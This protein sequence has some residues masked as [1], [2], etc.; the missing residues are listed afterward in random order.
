MKITPKTT[1]RT[2]IK[3]AGA[4][5]TVLGITPSFLRAMGARPVRKGRL[6]DSSQKLNIACVGCGGKGISDVNDVGSENIV[7]LC[8]VD[9]VQAAKVYAKYP[10]VPK[11]KDFREML[12][13]MD[14]EIDAVT[15]STPD[16]VHYEVGMLAISMGKHVF[17]QKPLTHSIWEA[18]E[19]LNAA[20][21]HGVIT[22]MGNQGHAGEGVRLAREW[23]QAD[24][25]GPVREVHI[26]TSK[27]EMGAY[28][29]SQKT[30]PQPGEQVPASLDW[31]LWV[32]PVA[33]RP[34]S[35][36]YHPRKWRNW[37][38]FGCGAL[39]DIGCHTMDAAFYALDLGAP[40]YV[41]AE[42]AP[43][44]D[45]TYPDWSVITYEFPARGSMPP[46]KLV[47]YD[48]GKLPPRPPG[49]EPSRSFDRRYGY[50]MVGDKGVICDQSEKCSSPRLLPEA[51]MRE[52][53]FPVRS[54]PRVPGGDAVQEWITACKGGP[55]PGSNFEYAVPLTEM[56]LLGN[57]AI[58]ARGR[59]VQWE[60]AGMKISNARDLEK[61][62]KP[63]RRAY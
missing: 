48:G 29:S 63:T 55:L 17:I 9:P 54:I 60:A 24:L 10:Q 40:A 26:W 61:Y 1:R 44:N 51:R 34:Y 25:I 30:R 13:K 6:L 19:L 7:A 58:R 52:T 32:G 38:D 28:K 27:M 46:V 4:S 39:G 59:R 31:N 11:F 5:A 12:R 23:V 43:F 21:R 8:D 53:T 2:F 50:Y 36:E 42:T 62:L 3:E 20:R 35:E 41:Q 14:A 22:Q 16:H 33:M 49:L 57:I 15:I 47:W 37:W 56:V 18:R 45:E